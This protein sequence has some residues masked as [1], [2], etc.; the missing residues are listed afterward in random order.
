MLSINTSNKNSTVAYVQDLSR[1]FG[2]KKALDH[3]S[4]A[5]P[6]GS[7]YGLVGANGAGKTT[8]IKHLL[9]SHYAQEGIVRVFDLDPVAHPVEVLKR[10]GYMSEN[11]DIPNW[12]T[13]KDLMGYTSA[14][15]PTWDRS[16]A[17][18]LQE[19]FALDV[20]SRVKHLSRGQRARMCLLLALAYRPE[21]LILDEP[22]SGLDPL[23]RKD[24][25]GAII[26]TIANEGR[27]VLFSSHLLDEVDRVADY[28]SILHEGRIV[29]DGPL[30]SLKDAFRKITLRFE[31]GTL[32]GKR[33]PL[34]LGS[35]GTH[36]GGAEWTYVVRGEAGEVRAA[37]AES[38]ATIVE[39]LNPNLDEIFTMS[40]MQ[41]SAEQTSR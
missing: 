26:R 41:G 36:L 13:V 29:V 20:Q 14:F 4:L 10:I 25:L 38:N 24:I 15:Y 33:A 37:V 34:I 9:G 30:E 12:M 7:V 8:L 2:K 5:I 11:R 22:S 40:A 31:P 19:M 17:T 32:E 18:E 28:V 6:T 35:L 3:V 21:F 16:F 27:T 23:V 1:R 39:D